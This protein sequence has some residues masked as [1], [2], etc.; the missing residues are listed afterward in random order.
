MEKKAVEIINLLNEDFKDAKCALNYQNIYQLLVAVMLSAQTTDKKVNKVTA[1]LFV[2][3][4]TIE[5]IANAKK[6]DIEKILYPLGLANVK[7]NNLILLSKMLLEKYNG[8]VPSNKKELMKLSG[9]GNKSSEVVLAEGFKIPSFPVDTHILRISK[10]LG[11]SDSNS[12]LITE[13]K[14]KLFFEQQYWIKLHHQLICF[15]REICLTRNPKCDLCKLKKY[16][17]IHNKK[18]SF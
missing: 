4:P 16:C 9:I 7:S 2:I 1:S 11:L 18:L 13:R 3:Y 17:L 12:A 5:S 10:R 15:G 8:V 6:E 14:L